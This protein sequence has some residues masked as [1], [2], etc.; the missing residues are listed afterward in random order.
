MG[1]ADLNICQNK[2]LRHVVLDKAFDLFIFKIPA[3]F[4][5][6]CTL[7]INEGLLFASHNLEWLQRPCGCHRDLALRVPD[8]GSNYIPR[9]KEVLPMAWKQLL[10]SSYTVLSP[11]ARMTNIPSLEICW[12]PATGASRKRPPRDLISW[13]RKTRWASFRRTGREQF[14]NGLATSSR[15]GRLT[16]Y[17]SQL[18]FLAKPEW[19]QCVALRTVREDERSVFG[20]NSLLR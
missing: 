19:E 7:Q 4:S 11:A 15:A 5:C 1:Q 18:F 2:T 3:L 20:I 6:V 8:P 17:K 13:R 16:D 12:L 9:K 10:Q 14:P